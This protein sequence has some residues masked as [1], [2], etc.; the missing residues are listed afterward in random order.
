VDGRAGLGD[1]GTLVGNGRI[2]LETP[3]VR[4][5]LVGTGLDMTLLHEELAGRI[6]FTAAID[7]RAANDFSVDVKSLNGMVLGRAVSANGQITQRVDAL[8]V[9]ALQVHVGLNHLEIDGTLRPRLAGRFVLEAP[10]LE[11]LWPELAGRVAGS[12]SVTGSLAEPVMQ[13]NLDGFDLTYRDQGV[14]RLSL[15]GEVDVNGRI[16]WAFGAIGLRLGDRDLGDLQGAVSGSLTGHDLSLDLSGGPV[17]AAVRSTGGWDG[18]TLNHLLT[19][20]VVASPTTGTWWLQEAVE[21]DADRD[22]LKI[23]PHC[24]NQPPAVLCLEE[25]EWAGGMF[26]TAGELQQFP[27]SVFDPWLGAGIQ[28]HGQA[29]ANFALRGGPGD[30]GGHLRWRQENTRLVYEEQPGTAPMETRLTEAELEI[31]F[32][33]QQARLQGRV[34]GDYGVELD[35]TGTIADPLTGNGALDARL[36]ARVPDLAAS[37][38]LINRF[39]SVRNLKGAVAANW[40]VTGTLQAP[41]ILGEARLTDGAAFLPPAGIDLQDITLTLGGRPG[42]PVAITGSARSGTGHMAIDGMLE[43]SET[44]AAVAE[45]AVTGQDF[46]LI[47]FPDQTV[48]ISPEIRARIDEGRI[49]LSGSVAVPRAAIKVE[50]LPATAVATSVDVVVHRE[51]VTGRRVRRPGPQIVGELEVTLG[52]EVRFQGFGIDTRLAGGMR[53]V[54]SPGAAAA[55][56]DG[57]VR[58]IDGRFIAYGTELSIER[59][60]LIFSGPIENPSVDARASREIEHDGQV[61]TAGVLLS[62]PLS[63]ILTRVFSEPTMSDA[64]ALSFLVLGRPM[65]RAN[66]DDADMLSGAALA[67]GLSQALPITRSLESALGL[68]EVDLDGAGGDDT[69]V[70][71]GKRLNKDLYVRYAYG[72]FNRIGTFFV[73]Y[74]LGG[75]VSI[76]AGSGQEQTLDLIY[77]VDR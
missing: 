3:S 66:E 26:S 44:T 13:A 6:D 39:V 19:R 25:T 68:D 42:Q 20:V 29:E 69:S 37:A 49:A 1:R 75:G 22:H 58:T 63:N 56:A 43:W 4:L 52:D 28:L 12:G 40:T 36:R 51:Q 50:S 48:T 55:T 14:A 73:N 2:E 31:V 57:T 32:T 60:S 35:M 5:Q 11:R 18:S 38:P 23:S 62:G 77:S 10:E 71:A 21:V 64:D 53:L 27:L 46:E 34:R 72:L 24:W 33:A 47:R 59:G 54:R 70:V 67:L 7:A 65:I 76:E 9:S 16:D 15:A 8:E 61:I 17:S 74:R 41:E 45:L 30:L